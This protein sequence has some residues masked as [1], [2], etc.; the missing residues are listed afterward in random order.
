MTNLNE[1]LEDLLTELDPPYETKDEL[2]VGRMLDRYGIPFFYQQPTI[3]YNE[4]KNEIWKPAFT[5][6]SHGG[7]IVDYIPDSGEHSREPILSRE[8]SYRYNQVP[9]VLLGPK[10]LAKQDWDKDFY[11]KIE[12]VYRQALDPMHY[13]QANNDQ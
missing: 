13:T 10:D 5:L 7:A 2:K 1:E 8:K 11:G 9:A 6:Y 3:I 12:H 4:G